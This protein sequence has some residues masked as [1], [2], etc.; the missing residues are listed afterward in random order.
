MIG[1]GTSFCLFVVIKKCDWVI[2][3]NIDIIKEMIVC[4]GVWIEYYLRPNL[5]S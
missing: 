5:S 4:K 3:E 1:V 2:L